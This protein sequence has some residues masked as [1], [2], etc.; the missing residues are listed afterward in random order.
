MFFRFLLCPPWSWWRSLL[1]ALCPLEC[2][3]SLIWFTV[4]VPLSPAWNLTYPWHLLLL[5]PLKKAV[6][7][8]HT[9]WTALPLPTSPLRPWPLSGHSSSVLLSVSSPALVSPSSLSAPPALALI[10]VPGSRLSAGPNPASPSLLSS[11]PVLRIHPA[12]LLLGSFA[13][14]QIQWHSPHSYFHDLHFGLHPEYFST[15]EMNFFTTTLCFSTSLSQLFQLHLLCDKLSIFTSFSIQFSFPIITSAT[16]CLHPQKPCDQSFHWA[17]RKTSP[18]LMSP[19]LLSEPVLSEGRY[20]CKSTFFHLASEL[21]GLSEGE[22][23]CCGL[24]TE[25][26]AVKA[27]PHPYFKLSRRD[28]WRCLI[29]G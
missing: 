11:S 7:S 17:P 15:T 24:D 14:P 10:S 26:P 2:T 21:S 6:A 1:C 29:P 8:S 3:H 18:A 5:K 12:L 28:A 27:S 16:L 4:A 19:G 22:T 9:P 13:S 23:H 20:P 25:E